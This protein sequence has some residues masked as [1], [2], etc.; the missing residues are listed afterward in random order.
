VSLNQPRL[1]PI[2]KLTLA[3]SLARSSPRG[4]LRPSPTILRVWNTLWDVCR[5]DCIPVGNGP[6]TRG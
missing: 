2:S 4:A 1:S 6:R 3:P 5:A